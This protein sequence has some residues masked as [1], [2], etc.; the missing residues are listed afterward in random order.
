LRRSRLWRIAASALAAIG[1]VTFT[2]AVCSG[3]LETAQ[4]EDVKAAHPPVQLPP[5]HIAAVN[6]PRRIFS[7]ADESFGPNWL[8][9]DIREFIA[10]RFYLIDQPGSQ[11]MGVAWCF[12]E[13]GLA[14]RP[15]KVL[16]MTKSPAVKKW[17]DAGVDFVKVMVDESHKRKLEVFWAHRVNGFDTEWDRQKNPSSFVQPIKATHPDWLLDGGAFFNKDHW[18]FAVPGARD[19]TVSILRELAENYD[20][21]GIDLDFSRGPPHLPVGQAWLYRDSVT[22][23]LRQIRGVFQEVAKKRGRPLLL[24]ARVAENVPGCHYDGLDIETWA[25]ENLVDILFLGSRSLDV[26]IAGFRR[27]IAGRNIK[28][29]PSLDDYH[30]TDGYGISMMRPKTWLVHPPIEFY[31]GV[32]NNWWHQGAEGVQTFNFHHVGPKD[33]LLVPQQKQAYREIGDPNVM[34]YLDKMFVVQRRY[35]EGG[36][37]WNWYL[38]VNPQPLLPAVIPAD[39]LPSIQT[40]YVSDDLMAAGNR[41][42]DVSL[43]VLLSGGDKAGDAI[44]AKLNG[45]MLSG[46]EA[47]KDGWWVFSPS[48]ESFAVGANLVSLCWR[49]GT[50]PPVEPFVIE[51]IEAHVRYRQSAAK[52][53]K[54]NN[55]SKESK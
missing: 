16:P 45:V 4:A 42:R 22:E 53:L 13:G 6:R 25:R 11:V 34:R 14:W 50:P 36:K 30:T 7:N 29:I 12:E 38:H 18:N 15:S 41:L 35:G 52:G 37:T 28:L 1:C 24:S 9:C 23:W 54:N 33:K 2:D 47:R 27:A 51:K 10:E 39:G 5:Q 55:Q 32:Y 31:R 40:L 44:Q 26:D 43:H 3:P 48:P 19:F 46:P 8:G 17:L 49:P 21:D 20:F